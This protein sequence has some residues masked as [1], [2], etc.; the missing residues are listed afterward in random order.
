M[1]QL[2]FLIL[3]ILA[4]SCNSQDKGR[5]KALLGLWKG[6]VTDSASGKAIEPMTLEFGSDGTV[7]QATGE[8]SMKTATKMKYRTE[9]GVL[10]LTEEGAQQEDKAGYTVSGDQLVLD[11][12]G[13]KNKFTKVK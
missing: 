4:I 13:V 5:D 2:F 12:A 7:T 6:N 8:G 9:N 11:Y 10:Y 3:T 1:K